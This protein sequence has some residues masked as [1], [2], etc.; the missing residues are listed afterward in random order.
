MAVREDKERQLQ[1]WEDILYN[2]KTF[3]K[4]VAIYL[5]AMMLLIAVLSGR[6]KWGIAAAI[7]GVVIFTIAQ[8]CVKV[9][10]AKK[11]RT[12]Q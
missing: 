1:K 10:S 9:R 4:G 12:G 5:L 7:G 11:E 8:T 6:A 3:L 2:I